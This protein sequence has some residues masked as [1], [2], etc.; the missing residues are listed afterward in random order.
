[1]CSN[2]K[3]LVIFRV[4]S[5]D[6]GLILY[7]YLKLFAKNVLCKKKNP[8][9][10]RKYDFNFSYQ[11]GNF[12]YDN[13]NLI[14]G[15][16]LQSGTLPLDHFSNNDLIMAADSTINLFLNDIVYFCFFLREMS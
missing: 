6:E 12:Y 1:M 11:N 7:R 2:S 3:S 13:L 10:I 8:T 9:L 5:S 16:A 15:Q 4:I 14:T